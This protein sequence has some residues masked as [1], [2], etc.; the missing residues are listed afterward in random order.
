MGLIDEFRSGNFSLYGQ[1][2]GLLSIVCL[3][4]FGIL[5]LNVLWSILAWIIAF[6]LIFIEIPL[7]LKCCPTS[8]KFDNFLGQFQNSYFRAAA[9]I[10]FAVIMWLA[11]GV[12]GRTLQVVSALLLTAG[13]VSYVI[14]AAR[15]QTPASSTITGG[16]GVSTIV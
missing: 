16:T 4:L 10:V 3:I 7:C 2:C 12:G 11:V 5:S 13:A 14:A 15:H 6:L 1:W 8:A 9:Y